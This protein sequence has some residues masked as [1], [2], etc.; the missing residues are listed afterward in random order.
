MVVRSPAP[1][2]SAR[3][4]ALSARGQA[5]IAALFVVLLVA[6]ALALLAASL[7]LRM[8]ALRQEAD[9]VRLAALADAALA[10]AL[11]H[12]A[13]E[14]G[15]PG[16]QPYPFGGGTLS[17]RVRAIS[18]TRYQITSTASLRE[19]RRAVRVEVVR[20]LEGLEVAGWRRVP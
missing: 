10:D 11:A 19:R 16:F 14:P 4:Q 9:T 3:G 13:V 2:P 20:T 18:P 15:F 7:N 5:L 1:A 12:L 6:L 17:S 8:R